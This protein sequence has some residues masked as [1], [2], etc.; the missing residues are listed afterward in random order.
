[1]ASL[2]DTLVGL[3]GAD[4]VQGYAPVAMATTPREEPKP[5]APT[6]PRIEMP[7]PETGGGDGGAMGGQSRSRDPLA[8]EMGPI[9]D[10]S[11]G[12][13]VGGLLGG[14]LGALLGAG[15]DTSRGMSLAGSD[16]ASLGI[17]NNLS[18]GQAFGYAASPFGMLGKSIDQQMLEAALGAQGSMWGVNEN[19]LSDILSTASDV[20]GPSIEGAKTQDA[21]GNNI[22]AVSRD[23][24]GLGGD[25]GFWG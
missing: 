4:R 25:P 3:F 19:T 20:Y 18:S 11:S 21:A 15:Y 7:I 8:I 10:Y 5:E 9:Y 24:V 23:S 14:S 16:L 2:L 6:V 12:S 22:D 13:R 1:M 17:P